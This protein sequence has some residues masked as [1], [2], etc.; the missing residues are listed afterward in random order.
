MKLSSEIL[1]D[2]TL[3]KHF[4]MILTALYGIVPYFSA[5]LR[6]SLDP[7]MILLETS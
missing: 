1:I 7:V 2:G 4:S 5:F 6:F 3:F